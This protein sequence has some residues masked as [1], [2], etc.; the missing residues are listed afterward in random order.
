MSTHDNNLVA[1]KAITFFDDRVNPH[2][3]DRDVFLWTSVDG[4]R[5]LTF[6]AYLELIQAPHDARYRLV[7]MSV[8]DLN[9]SSLVVRDDADFL[10]TNVPSSGVAVKTDKAHMA[11]RSVWHA[12]TGELMPI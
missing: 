8:S 6:D 4:I 2:G 5:R 9:D 7:R 11:F 10:R 12:A 3:Y 1:C